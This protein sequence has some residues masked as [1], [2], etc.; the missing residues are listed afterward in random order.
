MQ[1]GA[2][3]LMANRFYHQSRRDGKKLYLL[4]TS[5]MTIHNRPFAK[6]FPSYT[7]SKTASTAPMQHLAFGMD[8]SDM[9]II[10]FHPDSVFTPPVASYCYSKDSMPWDDGEFFLQLVAMHIFTFQS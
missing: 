3:A 8:P 5:T 10:N 2:N 6:Q 1:I 4:H 7:A 9:Q